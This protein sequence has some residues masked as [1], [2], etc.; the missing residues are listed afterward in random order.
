[1]MRIKTL[2]LAVSALL[3]AGPLSAQQSQ[4]QTQGPTQ[5]E[6][7]GEEQSL[8]DIYQR[9]VENDPTVREAEATY[10]ANAQQRPLARS[11]LL[12]S[13][14][15]GA[16]TSSNSADDPNP[17]TNF[18]TGEPDPRYTGRNTST[19][20]DSF[21]LSLTQTVFDWSRIV[22][23]K[24]ADKVVARAET[25]YAAAK[26]DLMVRVA[27]AYFT[28]L[29]QQDT[30]AAQRAARE[31]LSQQLE[32]AQ[33][34]FEVGLIAITEVQETQAG[35]DNAVAQEILAQQQLATAEEQLREI[36]G[37][38]VTRLAAP[39]SDLPLQSPDPD[40]ADMWVQAALKQNPELIAARIAAD[41]AQ[42]EITIARAARLP[43]LSFSTSY[44]DNTRNTANTLLGPEGFTTHSLS[45]SEGY[46]WSLDLRVPLFSGGQLS[47]RVQQGVYQHRATLEEAERIARQT[48]RQ[49]RDAYLGVITSISSVRALRQAQ[50]SAETALRATEAGFEVG[51]RTSVDVIIAQENL[52]QAQTQYAQSRYTYIVN[53]LALNRAAGT[54]S[55]EDMQRVDGWLTA[56]GG[57]LPSSSPAA[58]PAQPSPPAQQGQAPQGQGQGQGQ[59]QQGQQGR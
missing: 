12:P 31:A 43:T 4:S 40:S 23:L 48:E 54:L 32:Q 55:V 39:G 57:T 52:R 36:I 5:T 26:Q 10:L 8:L 21:S 30:L 53:I 25:Q 37:E 42:D 33:R 34:R 9:A 16:T 45:A 3:S 59:G 47:S 13:L 24:Q 38:R 1:M 7:Q 15:L 56:A 49:A 14:Q 50:Q 28:V 41:V 19:D 11:Q 44:S 35:Y 29:A 2:A 18:V 22:T 58:N 27:Q 20:T 51:T 46:Q 6:N 17:P